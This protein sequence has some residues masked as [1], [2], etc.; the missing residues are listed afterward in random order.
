MLAEPNS[1][2]AAVAIIDHHLETLE[3]RLRDM[4]ERLTD[5]RRIREAALRDLGS[6]LTDKTVHEVS[7]RENWAEGDRRRPKARQL[8]EWLTTHGPAT[9]KA[10]CE[11]S[12]VM[13][14][15]IRE[16]LRPKFGFILV[17]RDMWDIAREGAGVQREGDP[18]EPTGPCTEISDTRIP[19]GL[20]PETVGAKGRSLDRDNLRQSCIP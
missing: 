6:T 12:G 17:G 4:Q 11:S 8:R 15:T 16:Y 3:D 10:I 19:S 1:A 14:G 18:L 9:R 20:P 2:S 7:R 13:P 5:L